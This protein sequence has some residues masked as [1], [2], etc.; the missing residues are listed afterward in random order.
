MSALTATHSVDLQPLH[1]F[2]LPAHARELRLL[3]KQE[4]LAAL[5][6]VKQEGQPF[7]LLGEG[8]NTV[9]IKPQVDATVWKVAF[10]GRQ[11]LGCD[12][13]CHHLRVWGGENWHQTVEWT[14]ARGWGGLENLALIPGCVGASPVQNIGAYGVELK[15]CVSAVHAFDLETEA[16][17][18]FTLDEC[19]FAYRDSVF[20]HAGFGR[21]VITAVDFALPVNWQPV[22][23]Y[24]DVAQRVSQ[25]GPIT[26]LNILKAVCAIRTEKLPDP[27]VLGNSGSFFKNPIISAAQAQGLIQHFPN[28]VN[29]PAGAGLVKLAA[30]WLIDQCGLK[31]HVLGGVAVYNKQALILVNSGTGQGSDL[32]QLIR[33]VQAEVQARF[34]VFLEPEPSLV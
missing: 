18:T 11:Y 24:G 15:D 13:V 34:G 3:V 22:L 32:L 5:A 12:G 8:S 1:T 20:K 23:G 25:F 4:D 7:L 16:E 10:K 27:V 19:E 6:R 14:V 28:I 29:Y 31:G 2:G 33:H 9:F 21:Y 17:R 30:G 26:P